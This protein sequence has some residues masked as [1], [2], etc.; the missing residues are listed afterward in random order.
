MKEVNV[1]ITDAE[2]EGPQTGSSR[3]KLQYSQ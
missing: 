1:H 2:S 3:S